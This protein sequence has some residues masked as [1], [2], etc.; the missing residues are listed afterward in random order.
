MKRALELAFLAKENNEVPVGAVVVLNGKII[1]EGRN[2]TIENI[3]PSSHAEI[4]AIKQACK[5][6][7]NYRL[8]D[9]EL[10]SSLEPCIM[11]CGAIIHARIKKVYFAA[12]EPKTGAIE[13]VFSL[14]DKYNIEYLSGL[15]KEDSVNLLQNFFKDRR[16]NKI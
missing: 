2:K 16:N 7:G 13:S 8:V 10:Y 1:G 12:H 6:L 4:V 15:M 9:C 5:F 11:C 14:L 3:D